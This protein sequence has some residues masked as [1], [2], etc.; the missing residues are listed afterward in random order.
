[1]SMYCPKC[2]SKSSTSETRSYKALNYVRRRKKCKNKNCN[3]LFSSYEIIRP[4]NAIGAVKSF[5]VNI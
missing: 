3:H 1:M 2:K 5:V 4:E